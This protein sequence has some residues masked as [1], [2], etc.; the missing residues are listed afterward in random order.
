MR[1]HLDRY[2]FLPEVRSP[3]PAIAIVIVMSRRMYLL[4][5]WNVL[6]RFVVRTVWFWISLSLLTKLCGSVGNELNVLSR[7]RATRVF[8]EI[9]EEVQDLIDII[10]FDLVECL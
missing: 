9:V 6:N 8:V 3:S 7:E 4:D 5:H 1:M 10:L 2:T